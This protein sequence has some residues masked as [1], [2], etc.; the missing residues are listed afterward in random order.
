ML[1]VYEEEGARN[2]PGSMCLSSVVVPKDVWHG[3]KTCLAM[4]R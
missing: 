4:P 1:L 2:M 3:P